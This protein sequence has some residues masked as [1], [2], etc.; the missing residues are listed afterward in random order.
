MLSCFPSLSDIAARKQ[1]SV[2]P[3]LFCQTCYLGGFPLPAAA[4]LL[5]SLFDKLFSYVVCILLNAN[6][7][8]L[9]VSALKY[10]EPA[11]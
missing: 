5:G 2:G 10:Q 7:F 11:G 1:A 8:F 6:I 3:F 9:G 4:P